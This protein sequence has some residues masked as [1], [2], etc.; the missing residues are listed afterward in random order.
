MGGIHTFPGG[1]VRDDDQAA[2]DLVV[3][4]DDVGPDKLGPTASDK[5]RFAVQCVAMSRELFAATGL[6][7]AVGNSPSQA[8]LDLARKNLLSGAESFEQVL[9]ANR[10]LVSAKHLFPVGV[11]VTPETSSRRFHAKCY[12]IESANVFGTLS[13]AEGDLDQVEW[14][15]P[16]AARSAWGEARIELDFPAAFVLRQLAKGSVE[17]AL[18]SLDEASS[19]TA[20]NASGYE[21]V[22]GIWVVPMLSPTL[23]PARH[24]NCI[25]LGHDRKLIVDPA[26]VEPAE[27][28]R[29]LDTI[30]FAMQAGD[31]VEAVL[32][33]HSHKDHVGS[34]E[35]VSQHFNVPVW[36]HAKSADSLAFEVDRMID[37]DE[38]LELG[39]QGDF[40]LR[41]LHTPGHHPGHLCLWHEDSQTLVAGDMVS[42][43]STVV[44]PYGHGGDMTAYLESLQRLL[45][46][47]PRLL[48][49]AHGFAMRNPER[50]LKVQKE[51]RLVRER[52]IKEALDAGIRGVDDLLTACY[53]IPQNLRRAASLTLKAHLVRL[54]VTDFDDED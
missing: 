44:I 41:C 17:S 37:D 7:L 9:I 22:P 40:A 12:L 14:W 43:L 16:A 34:A 42:G 45:D 18:R 24:T 19:F 36:A 35:L 47:R 8:A 51:H 2:V 49:P 32:L 50:Y 10:L 48:L 3:G 1:V 25:I 39:S 21:P 38:V 13:L 29:L 54:G 6:L 31:Q 15:D 20:D 23:A 46:L 11:F 53:A 30:D 27:Q 4:L 33:T 28:Q 26:A 52:Q 5:Q